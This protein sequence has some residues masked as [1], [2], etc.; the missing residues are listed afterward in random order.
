LTVDQV[1]RELRGVR[2]VP[3]TFA[4]VAL[5]LLACMAAGLWLLERLAG[6]AP[7]WVLA[8]AGAALVT[9]LTVPLLWYGVWRPLGGNRLLE[10]LRAQ[11]IVQHAAEGIIAIDKHGRI[12]SLNPAAERLFGY[13]SAE[14]G[15]E[16]ITR[17]FMEPMPRRQRIPLNDNLPVGTILGLAAGAREMIGKR[18]NGE[19]FPLELAVSSMSLGDEQLSIAFTRDVSKRKQAQRYL[20]A[21][22]AATCILAESPCLDDAL[23]RILQA[24]GEALY[25]DVGV[26]WRLDPDARLLRCAN[27]YEDSTGQTP[28]TSADESLTC[29]PGQGLPGRVW[30]SGQPGW[31]E[32]LSETPDCPCR[33]LG[34]P[35]QLR[36]ALAFPI[37]L[38]PEV[39]GVLTFFSERAQ[40][41]DQQLLDILAAL[42]HQLGQLVARQRG[43]EMLRQAKEEAEAASRAKSEFLANVSHEIRTPLNGILGMTELALDTPLNTE[44]REYLELVKTS[45]T[46]L[47]RVINDLLDF[48]KIEAGRLELEAID[49][50]LCETLADILKGLALRAHQ[51]GLEL[52]YHIPS[53]VPDA[54]VGDPGRL[55]Q[56]LLNLVGNAIKF[57]E[58]GQIGVWVE[59]E[60]RSETEV[61]LHFAVSDTGI[62]IPT[63]KLELIFEPFR[64]AD[65][66][67]TRRYGGTGLGLAICGR[68]IALMGGRIWVESEV[69]R[70]STFHF[71]VRL[72]L[73]RPEEPD[74]REALARLAEVTPPPAVAPDAEPAR[75]RALHI[76][77]AEDN[78]INQHLAVRLLEKHG[79]HV[80][81]ADNGRQALEA[82]E[83]ERFDL[84]LM[85]VQMPL[86]GGLEATAR[87][88]ARESSTGGHVPILA[89]TA[90]AMKGDRERCLAAGMDG[91]V[92][93]PIQTPDLL[94]AMAR[95]VPAGVALSTSR[96]PRPDPCG[97]PRRQAV[98]ER[99][100]GDEELLR[101]AI[102]LFL[103][104]HTELLER[105]QHALNGADAAELEQGAH[106]LKGAVRNFGDSAAVKLAERLE[107]LGRSGS[108]AGGVALYAELATALGQLRDLLTTWLG[109]ADTPDEPDTTNVLAPENCAFD[110]TTLSQRHVL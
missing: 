58:H 18:Q 72:A 31:V 93:K 109:S 23:P 37:T 99:L 12:V 47:L 103:E 81:V 46:T 59:E 76:L 78:A 70:G 4:L 49:F 30:Y 20:T 69:G 8:P 10:R 107:L 87:I 100:G 110:H 41:R 71:T 54:L 65:G 86:M 60:A 25:W 64:Q 7:V 77:L 80:T 94:Q 88:R 75:P 83:R 16:P 6:V 102:Q 52:A 85:D 40:K 11:R 51:K 33:L 38:G 50:R 108:V 2:A 27:V 3:R 32:D 15:G 22:Y 29:S 13:G 56:V 91:Y 79:H 24:I 90:H 17:L 9:A 67:T 95:V 28:K 106:A 44:Q 57:T 98:L 21:H 92:V 63:D 104:G 84:V 39:C 43:E 14:V 82:V 36:G 53:S 89:L 45:G 61:C 55:R 26:F 35:R 68:L 5:L 105:V 19:T 62:G 97:L 73:Q 48:S 66:S 74:W 101:E 1:D 96:A 34:G 42:G